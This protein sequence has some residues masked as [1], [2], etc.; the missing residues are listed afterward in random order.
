MANLSVFMGFIVG[1]GKV[2]RELPPWQTSVPSLPSW[3][4]LWAE[5]R[6]TE[7]CH[8]GKPD[9]AFMGFIVGRGEVYR[10]L[11][12]WQTSVPSRLWILLWGQLHIQS[13]LVIMNSVGLPL[14]LF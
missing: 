11:P 1:R 9:S 14:T 12:P 8:H 4:L 2:Y 6:Y 5:V 3:V 7:N 10:E 13:D